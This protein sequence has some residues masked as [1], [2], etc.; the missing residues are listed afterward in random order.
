MNILGDIR[1]NSFALKKTRDTDVRTY[2]FQGI[3]T[4]DSLKRQWT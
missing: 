4:D 3:D 2:E 1:I